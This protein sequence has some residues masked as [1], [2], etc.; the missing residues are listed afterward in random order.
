MSVFEIQQIEEKAFVTIPGRRP[1]KKLPY[2][3]NPSQSKK[4]KAYTA[5]VWVY[6]CAKFIA[7]SLVAIP[8][9][10][11]VDGEE[12]KP[13]HP[14]NQLFE[15]VNEDDNFPDT[16]RET[17]LDYKNFGYAFWLPDIQFGRIL[18]FKRLPMNSVTVDG[19]DDII[20][21]VWWNTH[22]KQ[23]YIPEENL[24]VFKEYSTVKETDP[25]P[26]TTPTYDKAQIDQ[27]VDANLNSHLENYGIPPYVFTSDSNLRKSD[28]NRFSD[29]WND[30]LAKI[31]NRFKAV[32]IGG[33]MKATPLRNPLKDQVLP[34]LKRDNRIEICAAFGINPALVGASNEVNRANWKQ[35][36]QVA[37][38]NTIIPDA[39]YLAGIINQF[40]EPYMYEGAKFTFYP[41]RIELLQEERS[42]KSERIC[43]E[44]ELGI[45]SR[46]AAVVELG[47]LPEQIGQVMEDRTIVDPQIYG[48][49]EL[50]RMEKKARRYFDQGKIEEFNFSSKYLEPGKVEKAVLLIRASNDIEQVKQLLEVIA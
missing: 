8:W 13:D 47:Y 7:N 11:E 1:L 27:G 17:I 26:P 37:Y 19:E 28:L 34:D 40:M 21:G 12:T 22:S 30:T 33:G 18:R 29:I 36:I 32:F 9:G 49:M 43:R 39:K 6:A 5:S 20:K 23:Y 24:V 48:T 46:E 35:Q 41:D 16:L 15:F 44:V 31:K 42:A 2:G 10:F 4:G 50:A 3:K 45:L 38:Q 14:A 25:Q